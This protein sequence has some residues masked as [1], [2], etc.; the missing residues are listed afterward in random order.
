M[1]IDIEE[2][3]KRLNAE[4]A[5]GN[6][7]LREFIQHE[8]RDVEITK[9]SM[10]EEMNEKTEDFLS[11]AASKFDTYVYQLQEIE[12]EMQLRNLALEQETALKD[13]EVRGQIGEKIEELKN[14]QADNP[15]KIK[16][17]GRSRLFRQVMLELKLVA[18][19]RSFDLGFGP[20]NSGFAWFAVQIQHGS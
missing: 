15:E 13:T 18:V 4:I 5:K 8:I 1:E 7:N 14:M 3:R 10:M 16:A 6:R 2:F 19:T 17:A 20:H 11:T 12:K 9:A